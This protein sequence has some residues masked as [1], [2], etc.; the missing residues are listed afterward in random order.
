MIFITI[1]ELSY[2]ERMYY[3]DLRN[4]ANAIVSSTYLP[5]KKFHVI[6]IPKDHARADDRFS[7]DYSSFD[8]EVDEAY[9]FIIPVQM[10]EDEYTV[11][12]LKTDD[13][14]Y[15]RFYINNKTKMFELD[16]HDHTSFL[17]N[18]D[19]LDRVI[20]RGFL[21]KY[22]AEMIHISHVTKDNIELQGM[23]SLMSR[24]N[25]KYALKRV[26]SARR[27]FVETIYENAARS[28]V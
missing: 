13:N 4:A 11:I 24:F 25:K 10:K 17:R 22:A 15:I 26:P 6:N 12:L 28:F 2:P 20:I 18:T 23:I 27:E 16:K 5:R 14:G 1:N 19:N 8:P 7:Y 9:S 3:D 21:Y